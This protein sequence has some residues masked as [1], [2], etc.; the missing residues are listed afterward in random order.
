MISLWLRSN[1]CFSLPFFSSSA[2][3]V[4]KSAI[5]HSMND[6]MGCASFSD[7]IEYT[8]GWELKLWNDISNNSEMT[9]I[10]SSRVK[11]RLLCS[12]QIPYSSISSSWTTL[13]YYKSTP[14]KI[15]G[16]A[17]HK[18]EAKYG[19]NTS[20]VESVSSDKVYG[21]MMFHVLSSCQTGAYHLSSLLSPSVGPSPDTKS[22]RWDANERQVLIHGHK[23][24]PVGL[25]RKPP[26]R[27]TLITDL[28]AGLRTTAELF[29]HPGHGVGRSPAEEHHGQGSLICYD[30]WITIARG[31]T[32][33]I[34]LT[35]L[36]SQRQFLFPEIWICEPATGNG[37][38]PSWLSEAPAAKGGLNIGLSESDRLAWII[39]AGLNYDLLPSGEICLLPTVLY[40][41]RIT[42]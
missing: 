15:R 23:C 14:N 40:A 2:E 41:V 36:V 25:D 22:S 24:G 6:G 34:S 37:Q 1:C 3:D 10:W 9:D 35:S 38:R 32:Q 27:P 8:T 7:I 33:S 31:L 21:G 30:L 16:H 12:L 28:Q 29:H 13:S 39:L 26:L 17:E 19:R 18:A 42:A 11:K 5:Q 20:G 4:Y